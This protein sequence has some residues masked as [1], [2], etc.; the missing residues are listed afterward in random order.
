MYILL[1]H[2]NG[3]EKKHSIKILD[4]RPNSYYKLL[5]KA[6]VDNKEFIGELSSGYCQI[7]DQVMYFKNSAI[8]MNFKDSGEVKFVTYNNCMNL[9]SS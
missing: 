2:K 8:K 9:H 6:N 4:A 1:L 7:I 3:S 5:Y